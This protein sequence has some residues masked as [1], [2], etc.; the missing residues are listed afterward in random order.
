MPFEG[1]DGKRPTL[2]PMVLVRSDRQDSLG[3]FTSSWVWERASPS[4]P[5]SSF[6]L[7]PLEGVM[8]YV[9]GDDRIY[10]SEGA[11]FEIKILDAYGRHVGVLREDAVPPRVTEA[12]RDA[13]IAEQAAA[14]R[15]HPEDVPF[16]ER[17]GSYSQLVLSYEGELWAQR[18]ARPADEVQHWVVFSPSGQEARRVVVPDITVES[19]RG[20]RIYGY[21]STELGIQTVVVLDAG[22]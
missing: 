8:R 6:D 7:I 18:Y 21:R 10:L 16:P 2:L 5:R 20:G 13:Y 15:P 22:R 11:N 14:D 3:V 4:D 19:V 17:F 1:R 12:D 9:L